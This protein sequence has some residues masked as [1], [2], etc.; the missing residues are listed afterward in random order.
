MLCIQ[1]PPKQKG[2]DPKPICHFDPL[3]PR[4]IYVAWLFDRCILLRDMVSNVKGLNESISSEK[5]PFAA[6]LWISYPNKK[7]PII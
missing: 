6:L 4:F 7:Y 2:H 5:R 1:T 3:E